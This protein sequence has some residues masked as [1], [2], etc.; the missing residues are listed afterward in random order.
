MASH[1]ADAKATARTLTGL[2]YL[3]RGWAALAF[4][5]LLWQTI[6]ADGLLFGLTAATQGLTLFVPLGLGIGL[7]LAWRWEYLGA[8]LMVGSFLLFQAATGCQP[9]PNPT[10][11]LL[12]LLVT[13]GF[14]LIGCQFLS[15]DSELHEAD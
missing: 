15:L 7:A 12:G 5:L 10:F 3:A 6:A 4:A 2:R 8:W 9:G 1:S 11:F 14:I 13:P